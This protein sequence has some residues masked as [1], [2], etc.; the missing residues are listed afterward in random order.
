MKNECGSPRSERTERRRQQVLEA[1]FFCF[2][3]EGFHGASMSRIAARANMSVGHIYRYFE[4]KEAIVSAIVE[5]D[6]AEFVTRL[7]AAIA[8]S[9]DIESAIASFMNGSR[10]SSDI[11]RSAMFIEFLAEAG[12]NPGIAEFYRHMDS[13]MLAICK[14][15][16][17]MKDNG[18]ERP[19]DNIDARAELLLLLMQGTLSRRVLHSD[20]FPC[21]HTRAGIDWLIHMI[22]SPDSKIA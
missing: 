11:D 2:R 17:K 3:E 1:A 9:G 22:M 15:V 18:S 6:T 19:L 16:L 4:S 13:Q 5:R 8:E 12:R 21:P 14:G 20:R 10:Q 7:Q